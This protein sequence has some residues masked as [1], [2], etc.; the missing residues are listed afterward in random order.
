MDPEPGYLALPLAAPS[1]RQQESTR[2]P[3]S[4]ES[5]SGAVLSRLWVERLRQRLTKVFGR[6]AMRRGR[7]V[8]R[9]RFAANS[10]HCGIIPS[11]RAADPFRTRVAFD[12]T[13]WETNAD[14]TGRALPAE[15]WD[16]S[17]SRLDPERRAPC[18]WLTRGRS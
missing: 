3:Q 4:R 14:G 8:R 9:D 17:P 6:D 12:I 7:P 1:K 18:V 11:P 5:G 16:A 15:P 13:S 2:V 10:A